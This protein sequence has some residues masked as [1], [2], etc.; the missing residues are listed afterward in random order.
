MG[1]SLRDSVASQAY[2][3][4]SDM[5]LFRTC[6][7]DSCAILITFGI[8][9]NGFGRIESI[10]LRT[11]STPRATLWLSPPERGRK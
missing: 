8:M 10:I 1:A 7:L 5:G 3:C 9:L 11:D 2:L 6:M 4:Q